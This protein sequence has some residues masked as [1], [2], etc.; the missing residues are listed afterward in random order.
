LLL[1]IDAVRE[2]VEAGDKVVVF[3]SSTA[4]LERTAGRG[5]CSHI[6]TPSTA[7]RPQHDD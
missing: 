2:R 4:V 1:S 7:S 3:S 6:R 5:A